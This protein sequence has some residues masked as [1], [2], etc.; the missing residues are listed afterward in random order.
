MNSTQI[1]LVLVPLL[2]LAAVAFLK[3]LFEKE[4]RWRLIFILLCI[5]VFAIFL[6]FYLN[7]TKSAMNLALF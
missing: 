6:F 1:Y 5:I 3:A 2:I 4:L 7:F